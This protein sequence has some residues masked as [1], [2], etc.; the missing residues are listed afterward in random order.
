MANPIKEF[1]SKLARP[2]ATTTAKTPV[3]RS[4]TTVKGKAVNPIATSGGML[5]ALVMKK[6][7]EILAQKTNQDVINAFYKVAET[8]KTK[9]GPW[10]LLRAAGLGNLTD[11]REAKYSGPAIDELTKLPAEVRLGLKKILGI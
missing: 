2:A 3:V 10:P 11:K 1:F 9:G 6:Q 7:K 8:L 5:E 4:T